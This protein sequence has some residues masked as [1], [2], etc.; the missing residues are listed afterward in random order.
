MRLMASSD[1][2]FGAWR[3]FAAAHS[4]AASSGLD[5]LHFAIPCDAVVEG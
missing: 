2:A 1:K 3:G 5:S 4:K